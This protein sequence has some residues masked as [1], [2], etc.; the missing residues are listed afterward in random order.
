MKRDVILF[1]FNVPREMAAFASV[2]RRHPRVKTLC[3]PSAFQPNTSFTLSR[4]RRQLMHDLQ[5]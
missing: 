4:I 3:T 1:E 2:D 5:Q